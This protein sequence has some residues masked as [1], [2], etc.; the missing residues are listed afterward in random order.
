MKTK[1]IISLLMASGIVYF[2]I[3]PPGIGNA[4]VET[5]G[6][7]DCYVIRPDSILASPKIQKTLEELDQKKQTL[8]N[9]TNQISQAPKVR[10]KYKTKTI[11]PKTITLYV[12]DSAGRISEHKVTSDGGFYIINAS[13][14]KPDTNE[15][16]IQIEEDTVKK[17][18]SWLKKIFK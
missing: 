7:P 6:M 8:E 4:K 16:E 18:K 14:L 9:L 5:E 2:S 11:N 17:E 3:Y 12:R 13:E 1:L 10:I 15:A